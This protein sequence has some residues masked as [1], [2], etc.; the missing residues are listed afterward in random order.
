MASLDDME[1]VLLGRYCGMFLP[2]PQLSEE[3]S[4]AMRVVFI[5]NAAG[6]KTGFR[7]KYEFVNKKPVNK[8]TLPLA[9]YTV[10][11]MFRV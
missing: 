9:L 8:R 11:L 1:A 5:S 2:G 10:E 7:A 3:R 6:I 4:S